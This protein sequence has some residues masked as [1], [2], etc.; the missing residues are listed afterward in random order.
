[1]NTTKRRIGCV[2]AVFIVLAF[3]ELSPFAAFAAQVTERSAVLTSSSSGATGV[4]YQI[5]FTTGGAAGAFVVD[6]C[7]N[8]PVIGQACTAPVGF[9]AST[10]TT[11]TGGFTATALDDNTIVVTGSLAASG[12][13]SVALAG[14]ANPSAASTIY[15]R[16]VTYTNAGG[17]NGYTS[18]DIGIGGSPIDEGTVAIAI[19]DTI[20]V[21]GAVL[22]SMTFCASGAAINEN[23]VG[24]TPTALQ[25]GE[26]VGGTVALM[27][28]TVSTGS[29][30][31][32][33][34]TN[35]ASGAVVSLK[36]NATDC[37]GLWRIGSPGACDILPALRDG[38]AP[39]EARFGVKVATATS[40]G[41][42]AS[43][44]F[45]PVAGSGYNTTTYAL[46]YASGNAT[47]VTS[48]YGDPFLDTDGAPA[49]NKNIQLTFGVS[50]ANDTP[51][52]V[53]A[54]DLNLVATGK[55]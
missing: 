34:S 36:S 44:T 6:V 30:Y 33:I 31:T 18:E 7:A 29:I 45:Q 40:T 5:N 37:G 51:A 14:I 8:S 32:Q 13:V 10:V 43:G 39:M 4:T 49:N 2:I 42:N 3:A 23:C 54:A 55:F 53:Y 50:V 16:I 35:A 17:A 26:Q 15:A 38:I 12:A 25:L 48:P 27:P 22:E 52:G 9:S 20:G 21:S 41:S 19:T 1:M 47:G 11:A 24:T 28:G 46:N